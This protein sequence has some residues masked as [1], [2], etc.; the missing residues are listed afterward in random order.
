MGI[1]IQTQKRLE[2]TMVDKGTEPE[3]ARKVVATV[4][5]MSEN[6][7]LY[8]DIL[9]SLKES[10]GSALNQSVALASFAISKTSATSNFV[11]EMSDS[12]TARAVG[13]GTGE[14]ARDLKV[15]A[16]AGRILGSPAKAGVYA[17]GMVLQKGAM[18]LGIASR[19]EVDKCRAAVGALIG[20]VAVTAVTWETGVGA[21]LGLV[22]IGLDGL[23]IYN[24]CQ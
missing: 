17:A 13:L 8:K 11:G 24:S 1:S 21:V 23:E 10:H 4:K 12:G 3:I 20:D 9:E 6:T 22:S 19:V 16:D 7:A 15:I 18:V 2:T 14:V 5:F